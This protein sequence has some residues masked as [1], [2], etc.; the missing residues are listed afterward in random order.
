MKYDI[1]KLKIL[2]EDNHIIAI[3][4]PAGVLVQGDETGDTPIFEIVKEYIRF[5]YNKP[6]EA[7]LG[8]PHRLDRP[9]SGVLIFAKTSKALVR[10]NEMFQDQSIDKE[11]VAI[12]KERPDP[13]SA[14]LVNYLVK[15]KDKN[16]SKIL[17]GVSKR[18]PD[19]KRCE[20]D[21][22]LISV[23]DGYNL[24]LIKPKTGRPHQ[25][26]VQ[27]AHIGCPIV[28]DFRYGSTIK[29]IENNIYLHCR[30]ME[31]IHPI[32]KEKIVIKVDPE[33]GMWNK[34]SYDQENVHV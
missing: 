26:R 27:L 33:G 19:A 13:L 25:I 16:T 8:I 12:V 24:L 30:K 32:K 18:N 6:G 4:K 23:L 10:L 17:D 14:T 1:S 28:G 34:F 31:F 3:N 15:D 20:L 9:V 7:W 5:T 2:Y 11:Y 22:N 29:G 21:Y